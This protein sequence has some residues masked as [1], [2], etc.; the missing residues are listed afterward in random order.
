MPLRRAIGVSAFGFVVAHFLVFAIL[1]VQS[2]ERV[3][4]EIVKR[5]YV[6]VGML[7]FLMLIPLG[8]TSNNWSIRKMG[9]A[10]WRRMHKLV[11]HW[12]KCCYAIFN[13]FI[14]WATH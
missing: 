7:S 4:Q 12:V 3:W 11:Y 6:T 5:P 9:A 1:D 14:K 2:L 10:A 13:K 8:I